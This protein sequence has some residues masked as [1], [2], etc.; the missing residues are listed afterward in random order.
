MTLQEGSPGA[1]MWDERYRSQGQ[2]WSGQ[3]N[4]H[5]VS[6]AAELT[7]GK[8]LDAGCGEGADAIWLA[9]HG[10][11]VSAVDF[12]AVALER[13]AARA[14]EVGAEIAQRI[15]WQ[16]ADL[17]NWVPTPRSY[18]LVSAQFL[19]LPPDKR[20]PL[21]RRLAA[22]VASGGTLLI[23]GHHP[24]DLQATVRRPPAPE[25]FYTG[26]DV[27]TLIDP[28]GWDVIVNAA[29]ERWVTDSEGRAVLVHDTVLRAQLR[30]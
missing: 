14:R 6:E 15:T 16:Q 17:T 21:F 2:M 23:V 30:G 26:S 18:D 19:H 5:L 25:L 22:A 27:A 20:E 12:S 9:E 10:W 11:H 13:G 4:I 8:A 24:S 28:G 29:R 1:A 7:P 3:P